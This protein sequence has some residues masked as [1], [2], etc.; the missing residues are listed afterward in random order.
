MKQNLFYIKNNN[1]NRI[2][3]NFFSIKYNNKFINFIE[4]TLIYTNNQK[5]NKKIN[6]NVKMKTMNESNDDEKYQIVL[7]IK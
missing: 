2:R 6:K 1:K 3:Q 5:K 4:I 7:I